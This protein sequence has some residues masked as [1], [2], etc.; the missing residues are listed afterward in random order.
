MD[1]VK[2]N[3]HIELIRDC[4]LRQNE[5]YRLIEK[6]ALPVEIER[7]LLLEAEEYQKIIDKETEKIRKYF[8]N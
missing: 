8:N 4:F 3:K 5:I 2:I 1:T 6:H 7:D